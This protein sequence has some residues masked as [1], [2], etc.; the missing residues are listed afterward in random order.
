V[1]SNL[2]YYCNPALDAQYKAEQSTGV[3]ADRQK[4]F[5]AIHQIEMT[6]FPMIVLYAAPNVAVY[7][8]VGHNYAPSLV[9]VGSTENIWQWWCNNGTC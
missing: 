3:A 2:Q 8:K 1:P 7:K 5:D 4:A 9:G 6:D